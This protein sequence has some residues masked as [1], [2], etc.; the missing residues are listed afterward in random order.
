[1]CACVFVLALVN[2]NVCSMYLDSLEP[3]QP[4]TIVD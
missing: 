4:D 2:V 1:M 3:T